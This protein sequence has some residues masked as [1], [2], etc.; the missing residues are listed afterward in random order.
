MNTDAGYLFFVGAAVISAG[1][2]SLWGVEFG[3]ISFGGLSCVYV[4][5]CSHNPSVGEHAKANVP[6]R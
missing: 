3:W 5:G 6:W 2:G 4:C 1:I